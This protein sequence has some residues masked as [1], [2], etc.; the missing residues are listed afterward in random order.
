[1]SVIGWIV[2]GIAAWTFVTILA[3]RPPTPAMH[4]LEGC[5]HFVKYSPDVLCFHEAYVDLG[6]DGPAYPMTPVDRDTPLSPHGH[7]PLGPRVR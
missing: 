5:H 4:P 2:N 1:M 3:D 6:L 7:G